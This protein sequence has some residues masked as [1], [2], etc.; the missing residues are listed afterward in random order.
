VEQGRPLDPSGGQLQPL[1]I[2]NPSI[3][4]SNLQGASGAALVEADR[5]V[6]SS[7]F[8]I[9]QS[10]TGTVPKCEVLYCAIDA[11]GKVVGSP[12]RIRDLIKSAGAYVA[13]VASENHPDSYTKAM[14]SSNDWHANIAL[15]IDRKGDKFALF[16]RRLFEAMFDE[17]SMLMAWVEL[18]PQIPGRDHPDAPGTIMAAEAGH[19]TFGG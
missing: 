8:K 16:F 15:V 13:V 11:Q 18:A 10:S 19:V 4:F 2:L 5:R 6:L 14:R 7:L 1:R 3:G 17:R 12:T 9:S